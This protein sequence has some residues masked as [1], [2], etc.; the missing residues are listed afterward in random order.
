MYNIINCLTN[1]VKKEMY[2]IAHAQV[3]GLQ[4]GNMKPTINSLWKSYS[5]RPYPKRK[6]TF[7]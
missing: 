3:T 1:S 7:L 6:I 2:P 4:S 5:K